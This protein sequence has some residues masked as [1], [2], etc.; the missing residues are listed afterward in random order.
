MGFLVNKCLESGWLLR[1]CQNLNRW[2]FSWMFD[3]L[4]TNR[5]AVL[6]VQLMQR[7]SSQELLRVVS[8]L[9]QDGGPPSFTQLMSSV[10]S[11]FCGYPEGEGSRVLSF[12]WYEDN[13]YKV[14]LGV[15][16]TKSHSYAY[17]KT[18]SE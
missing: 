13:N 10:S 8:S 3:W 12:N 1:F 17:D 6:H 16:G 11:L 9:F 4:K 14:F 15:N 7:D 18:T 2:G 5:P